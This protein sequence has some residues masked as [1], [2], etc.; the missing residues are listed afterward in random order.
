MS[1]NILTRHPYS[2]HLTKKSCLTK[3]NHH[4]SYQYKL[5]F[6]QLKTLK[7][8]HNQH[9]HNHHPPRHFQPIIITW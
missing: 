1:T 8:T 5:Y 9:H 7:I 4:H 2:I 3:V 6:I